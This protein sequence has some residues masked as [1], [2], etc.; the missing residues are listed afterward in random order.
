MAWHILNTSLSV[1]ANTMKC[2]GGLVTATLTVTGKTDGQDEA[3]SYTASVRDDYV[4]PDILWGFWAAIRQAQHRGQRNIQSSAE[5]QQVR[6]SGRSE[7]Q[8]R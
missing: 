1:D 4:I 5:L 2:D 3:N 8:Q 6:Q 7:R